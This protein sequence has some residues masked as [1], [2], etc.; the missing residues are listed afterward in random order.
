M[1]VLITGGSGFIGSRLVRALCAAGHTVRVVSRKNTLK[2]DSGKQNIELVQADLLAPDCPLDRIVEGCSVVFN[3]AGELHDESRMWPLHVDATLRL[4]NE[5]KRLANVSGQPLHWV[6]LSS[7]GAYGPN[8]CGAS[9]VRVVTEETNPAPVGTYEITKTRA[10]EIV[11]DAAEEGV[12]SYSILRPSNVFGPG[13][14]NDSLRQW[15]RMIKKRLYFHIG[16]PGAV[17]T[18]VH[19]DDVVAALML[20]GFDKRARG[21][22]F[23]ISNDCPQDELVNA[24]ARALN[25]A[26]PTLRLPEWLMRLVAGVFS[27]V[28]SFPLSASRIDSLVARTSYPVDKMASI[29]GYRPRHDVRDTIAE[30]LLDDGDVL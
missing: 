16:P 9:S 7:V 21:E 2:Q 30:A 1:R 17:S 4:I 15:G 23:N 29:L 3:C 24:M 14:P 11:M 10:D 5:C 13:M 19:V 25:V 27:G 18:Y 26:A 12:F 8:S 28:H 22:V 6:Q 20:C